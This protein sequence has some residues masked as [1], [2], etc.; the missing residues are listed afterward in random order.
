LLSEVGCTYVI[1]GHSER[2]Q[3]FHETDQQIRNKARAAIDHDLVPIICLGETAQEHEKKETQAVIDRQLNEIFRGLE[4][5]DGSDLMVAYEPVWAIGTGKHATADQAQTIHA[6]I[7]SKLGLMFR[8]DI[9]ERVRVIYGGSVTADN[10]ANFMKM[11]D[12]DGLLVG[13]ASLDAHAFA[14][15]VGF[16]EQEE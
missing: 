15:I 7:R 5:M 4:L 12:I 13:S 14:G 16:N 3:Y 2:R 6:Q 11:P 9:A 8:S 10:A 1:V